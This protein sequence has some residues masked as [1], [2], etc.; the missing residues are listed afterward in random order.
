MNLLPTDF[1]TVRGLDSGPLG[2]HVQS[3]ITQLQELR[4]RSK[5]IR[6]H[7]CLIANLS[8]WLERTRRRLV[9]LNE[10]VI[11]RFLRRRLSQHKWRM[12]ERPALHRFLSVLRKAR[13]IPEAEAL[14]ATPAQRLCEDFR[15]YLADERGCSEWTLENYGRHIDRFVAK[16]FGAGPVDPSRLQARD[17]VQFVHR[18][19]REHNRGHTLQVVTAL[20]S[21][22]RFLHYGGQI[23][24][25]LSHA[26]PMVAHWQ[27]AELP[28]HLPAESVQKVLDCC[29]QTTAVG[30]RNYAILLLLA[31]LGLRAGEIIVLQLGDIDWK[32]GQ[33]TIRSNKGQGWARL[34]LPKDVGKA[35][36]RYLRLDRPCCSSRHVFVRMVAP[37][38]PLSDSPV[39][40]VLTRNALKKA[41]VDSARKGAHIFRHSLATQMLRR[42]ASLD[43]IGQVLRHKDPDTTAIYA[44]VD[45][46][47]LRGLAVAWPGGGR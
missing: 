34:P 4:Y 11:E 17:V 3:Y 23:D 31:R 38:E 36:S 43:E 5:T 44:K 30:R 14:P 8:R 29:D 39:I 25:D 9:D 33:I 32:N 15:C 2:P 13:L 42:G 24:T 41:G 6:A 18:N 16:C 1:K 26:V 35:L 10:E 27:K 40:S 20:R 19:A 12:G 7:L 22:L 21:F 45:L 46:E 47:A 37:Y 28:K